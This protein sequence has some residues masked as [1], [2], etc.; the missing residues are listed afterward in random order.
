MF[1][2]WQP[3]FDLL[4]GVWLGGQS[5]IECDWLIR[6]LTGCRSC[7][8]DGPRRM[9]KMCKV[10]N[11]ISSQG[12]NLRSALFTLGQFKLRVSDQWHQRR[13]HMN[14]AQF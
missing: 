6:V 13:I 8:A 10:E 7:L 4:V 3:T 14:D 11:K 5:G 9:T 1:L 12:K 2:A